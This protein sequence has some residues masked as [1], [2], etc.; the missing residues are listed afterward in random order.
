MV[1]RVGG[2]V[3]GMDIEAMVN[4]IMEAERMPLNRL[5]QQQT[6][7]EWKRDAFRNINSKLLEL[8]NMMLDMKMTQTY[9]PKMATSSQENAVKATAN[10]SVPNG[11]YEIEVNKLATNEMQVGTVNTDKSLAEFTGDHIFYTYD[12]EGNA[13]EHTLTIKEGDTL[14]QVLRRVNEASGNTVRAF[15]DAESGNVVFETTRTGVY[16]QS[17]N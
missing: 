6:Q 13:Q 3:S 9:N 14:D 5:K 8:D 17:E 7:L 16:N 2:I 10:A 1:M 11:T 12:K 4:K 15:H